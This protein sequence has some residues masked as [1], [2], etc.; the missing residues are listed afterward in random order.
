LAGKAIVLTG[1][2]G[3]GKTTIAKAISK[4]G[5]RLIEL[6]TLAVETGA[7][8]E[9][10]KER[11]SKVIKPQALKKAIAKILS[12]GDS[13]FL[14]EG[15]FGELVPS[16]FVEK[17]IVLRTYPFELKERLKKKGYSDEKIRENVEAELLD[18]C[19]IA[20]VKAFGENKVQEI[21]TSGLSPEEA[22]KE[23]E[24][25]INGKGMPP[26]CINWISRLESEGKLRDLIP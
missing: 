24:K 26:G 2:P 22:V 5:I 13:T 25:A 8:R 18:S 21:D 4:T 17:A 20:A 9:I 7:V 6:N 12:D 19:L 23:V 11:N 1:T 15:H 16:R 10:D 3:V 14:I